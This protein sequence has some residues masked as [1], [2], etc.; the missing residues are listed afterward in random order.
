MGLNVIGALGMVAIEGSYLPQIAR[1][2]RIKHAGDVSYFF[3]A[4]NM[5]GRILALIYAL[6]SGNDVFVAG[7]IVGIALRLTLLGQVA[8]YRRRPLLAR[9]A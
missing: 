5:A 1:L 2:H 4:L 3:P 9:A 7:F 8:W 6:T